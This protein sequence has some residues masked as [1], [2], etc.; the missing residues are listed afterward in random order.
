MTQTQTRIVCPV[1]RFESFS[2]VRTGVRGDA[3]RVVYGC[4][5]C[6][7]QFIEPPEQNLRE[8]YRD[9]YRLTHDSAIG[10]R[11]TPEER[12]HLMR[13][14]IEV[15]AAR[16]EEKIPKG[17][18]VLEIGCSSGYFLA[19]LQE[20]G[21][22]VYGNEWNPEDAAYVREVGE[23]PCEEGDLK[24]IYPGRTFTA[25][26][27]IH[28]LEHQPDPIQWLRDVKSRL[29]GG[30]YLYL[31]IPSLNDAL[32][33]IYDIPEYRDFWYRDAHLTY[34]TRET[35]LA[36]FSALG[37]EAG[38]TTRQR[39]GFLDHMNWLL[40]RSPMPDFKSAT[41]ELK[42]IP[43]SHSMSSVMNRNI[44]SL[45]KSYRVTLESLNAGDTIV[46]IGRRREI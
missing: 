15:P 25:I 7:L 10:H 23:I 8:Y 36:A 21:Y 38:V 22:D 12:F 34:W 33:T 24:D 13:G 26:A 37:M 46:V 28:V 11:L 27:A 45:D 1:C 2:V 44:S 40:N 32:L 42:P 19:A 16:F 14:A 17:S 3:E 30:G 6:F 31:E 43:K 35:V 39:Y 29:I 5:N 20:R 18:S 41:Q 9:Q 4:A